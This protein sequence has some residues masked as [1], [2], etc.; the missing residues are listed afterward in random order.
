MSKMEDFLKSSLIDTLYED[1]FDEFESL[2]IKEFKEKCKDGD[3]DPEQELIDL[4]TENVKD[5][6]KKNQ[7]RK[8]LNHLEKVMYDDMETSLKRAYKLGF[9]DGYYFKREI[10][11]LKEE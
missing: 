1:R 7:I 8:K 10:E 5:E 2:V 11:N 3:I 4:I 6:E 9:S